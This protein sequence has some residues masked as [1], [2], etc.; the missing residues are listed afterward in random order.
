VKDDLFDFS[1]S[2]GWW[3]KIAG[4]EQ[5]ITDAV[6][7][8]GSFQFNL[9][10]SAFILMQRNYARDGRH[11][12]VTGDRTRRPN[13]FVD[14]IA[15]QSNEDSDPHHRCYAEGLLFDNVNGQSKSTQH[16]P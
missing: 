14:S 13:V 1:S 16:N 6:V 15:E 5:A 12:F 11:D 9:D 10:R 2:N 8:S 3:N 4:T 7:P